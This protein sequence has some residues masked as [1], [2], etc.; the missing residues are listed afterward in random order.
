MGSLA[1][2]MFRANNYLDPSRNPVYTYV[3]PIVVLVLGVGEAIDTNGVYLVGHTAPAGKYRTLR[4]S[5]RPGTELDLRQF[6]PGFQETCALAIDDNGTI[7]GW[8]VDADSNV[9]VIAW[10]PVP[11]PSTF[12]APGA[13]LLLLKAVK[14][15]QP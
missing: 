7:A 10:I 5:G 8:G 1:N 9:R 3:S 12:V 2:R 11:E 14:R 4:W 13:G 15:R 6:F